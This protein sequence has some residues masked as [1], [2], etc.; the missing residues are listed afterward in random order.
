MTYKILVKTLDIYV[1][2]GWFISFF[3]AEK[4]KNEFLL[5]IREY[6]NVIFESGHYS[7]NSIT[8]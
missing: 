7:T 6:L 5:R 3:I 8:L 2:C 4:L 1:L